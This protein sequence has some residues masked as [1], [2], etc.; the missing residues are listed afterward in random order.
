MTSI[1]VKF[2]PSTI[3]N[4][5]GVI[6]YQLIKDR[7]VKLITSRFRL[8]PKEWDNRLC[9]VKC[10]TKDTRRREYLISIQR[11]LIQEV[12]SLKQT[13]QL[14]ISGDSQ[15]LDI[16]AQSH[17]DQSL[18]G[19][20]F[21]FMERC[22]DTL[23]KDGRYK[24]SSTYSTALRSFSN[25]RNGDDIRFEHIDSF[26]IKRYEVWLKAKGL[27]LNTISFYMRILRAVYNRAVVIG[28]TPQNYPFKRVYTG[29]EKT[30]KRAVEPDVISRLKKLN[31]GQN[32]TLAFARDM[33]LFSFYTRGMA[34]VDMAHLTKENVSDNAIVYCRQKTGQHLTIKIEPCIQEIIDRYTEQTKDDKLL[35]IISK[36]HK[37]M[38]ALRIQNSRLTTISKVLGLSKP[39]TSYVPRHSWASLAYHS[40]VSLEVISQSMGHD[41]ENTTR[42]Y[43]ASLDRTVIDNANAMLLSK[44]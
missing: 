37:Y 23:N 20:L 41:N 18:S 38:S 43:L 2:R 10:E 4:K 15:V 9:V 35:P 31:L 27:T 13:S 1:R 32:S 42:I 11:A 36:K 29:I 19:N 26:Q 39:L 30:I 44:I 6:Y 33:F 24:T 5:E 21:P 8:F 14:F 22:I 25:F 17:K 12:E 7:R 28:L 34:Y 16:I 40:G 3:A